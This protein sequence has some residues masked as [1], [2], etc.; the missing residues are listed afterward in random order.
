MSRK[1]INYLGILGVVSFLSYVIA[2]VFSPL[3]YPDYN[4]M[5]QAVSDLFA[6]DSPS[7]NLWNQL[8]VLYSACGMV[9][10]TLVSVFIENKLNKTIRTGIHLFTIMNWISCIGYGL[11]PLS[12]SG[13]AGAFQDIMHTY[14]VTFL[15]VIFSIVSLVFI[16][17][18]GFRDRQYISLSKWALCSLIFMFIG[19]I[20]VGVVPSEYFGIPERFS[21]LSATFFNAVLG[22]Y[23]F[24]SFNFNNIHSNY[25]KKDE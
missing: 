22:V 1:L 7:L 6:V 10:V 11:F 25:S 14:V 23:L 20:G 8:S 12:S 4:W 9:S 3:A 2:V 16:I 17:I 5:S 24:N 13:Y 18:G 21:V 15:V 19:A